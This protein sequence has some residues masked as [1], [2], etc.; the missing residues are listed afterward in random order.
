MRISNKI[1]D[2]DILVLDSSEVV[3]TDGLF[4]K[5]VT[6]KLLGVTGVLVP[7][8]SDILLETYIEFLSD[9]NH[10][11]PVW[12][13]IQNTDNLSNMFIKHTLDKFGGYV[14]NIPFPLKPNYSKLEL[15]RFGDMLVSIGVKDNLFNY[16]NKMLQIITLLSNK[17]VLYYTELKKL[18]TSDRIYIREFSKHLLGKYKMV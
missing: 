8:S 14:I 1:L 5:I 18:E 12:L 6:A 11:L 4:K 2:T 15:N 3:S 17:N 10:L 16:K 13:N 9:F 7:Y